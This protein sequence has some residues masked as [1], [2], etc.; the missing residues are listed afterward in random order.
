MKYFFK[1]LLAFAIVL[2]GAL[3]VFIIIVNAVG[4]QG[5]IGWLQYIKSGRDFKVV[6]DKTADK[7]NDSRY[8]GDYRTDPM[9]TIKGGETYAIIY[10][11]GSFAA[12]GYNQGT[13]QVGTWAYSNARPENNQF[14]LWGRI[15]KFDEKGNVYDSKYGLVGHL[16][17]TADSIVY[18]IPEL[19]N[20]KNKEDCKNYC[21]KQENIPTCA[22]Y[23]EK[24]NL[25]SKEEAA[26][27]R[28]FADV[29]KGEGPGRCKDEKSCR[30]YCDNISNINECI[31]FAEKHNFVDGKQLAEAKKVAA[32]LKQGATLPGNCKDKASCDNYCKLPERVEECFAFAKAAGFITPQEAA[33]AERVLPLI[34]NGETPG[35]C[36]IKAECQIYCDNP[37]NAVE[38]VNFA[39][40]AG[41]VS[42][43]EA[44]MARKTGGKGPGGCR[45]K[46]SCEL[47]CN[48]K[49][50][51]QEC[52]NF[53]KKYNLISP[54]KL[55]EMED[56]M[57]R[58]RAG[59]EQMPSE[60]IQCLKDALGE[61]IIGQIQ[62]GNFMPGPDMGETIKGCFDKVLPQLQA[63]LQ[64]GFRQATP[65]TLTC[66][67][68][69]LGAEGFNKIQSGEAPSPEMGDILRRCFE[70]MKIEGIKKIRERLGQ[71]PPE[72]KNC[73]NKKLGGDTFGKIERG[74]E[75]EIG[76]EIT[77]IIQE[78]AK[79]A[80]LLFQ[81]KMQEGLKSAPPEV[82]SCVE[83]KLGNVS[84]RVRI[85]ELKGEAD[86]Q[87]L[88]Q[89]CVSSFKP[90]GIPDDMQIPDGFP[91]DMESLKKMQEQYQNM[92]PQGAPQGMT[93]PAGVAP[94]VDCSLFSAAPSCNYVPAEFQ[95]IC[96]Q[97][98][99]Q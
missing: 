1:N 23:G 30:S 25:I 96:R 57:G 69:G 6:F 20:C 43:E 5:N 16:N 79:S 82:R 28:K 45:S 76:P 92:M 51:Q 9:G 35:K 59:L 68:S 75:V 55:K 11:N 98:K 84:E 56:G 3:V 94:N 53:A 70:S 38:C 12:T 64:E 95:S 49:E 87:R 97:C 47:F 72:M 78:C 62:S 22:A 89:E 19:G 33:E 88:V 93:P 44:D 48:K 27:A 36:K 66:L 21:S 60:A 4:A 7:F 32:A 18:P 15:Y 37:D 52:F 74:E 40:K 58:L 90:Q 31:L 63:K 24:N 73:I 17:A 65:E 83:S 71:M 67:K 13:G 77:N 42:K 80:E 10:K 29:L 2:S 46:E 54:D 26:R 50:N 99:G 85:G 41:F 14:S 34:K 8:T 81:Q 91:Q 39:E 61:G 86:I